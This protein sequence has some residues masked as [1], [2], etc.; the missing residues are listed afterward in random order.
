MPVDV[1]LTAFGVEDPEADALL[2]FLKTME[3]RAK[4]TAYRLGLDPNVVLQNMLAGKMPFLAKGGAVKKRKFAV[5][6]K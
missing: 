4:Y 3:A 5:K 6:R 1:P 2:P